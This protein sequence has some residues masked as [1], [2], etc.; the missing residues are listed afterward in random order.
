MSKEQTPITAEEN[1][2]LKWIENIERDV[3]AGKMPK[4]SQVLFVKSKIKESDQAK[5]QAVLEALEREFT[6]MLI[7]K[8]SGETLGGKPYYETQVKPKYER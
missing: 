6:G 5:K 4:I 7:V 2:V 3:K 1:K 8:P